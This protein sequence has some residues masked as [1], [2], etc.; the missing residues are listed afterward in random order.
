MFKRTTPQG[1]ARTTA[2]PQ[3]EPVT[4]QPDAVEEQQPSIVDTVVEQQPPTIEMKEWINIDPANLPSRGLAYPAGTTIRYRPYD[5]DE[6]EHVSENKDMPP[7]EHYELIL[8]GIKCSPMP[9]TALTLGDFLFIMLNR[10]ITSLGTSEFVLHFLHGGERYKH[11]MSVFNIEYEDIAAP[12]LPIVV[13][14][15]GVDVE[16]MP[17]T[18]GQ[19][20]EYS[21][22]PQ[23][24]LYPKETTALLALQVQ[25]MGLD[26]SYPMIANS[27]GMA[28]MRFK[29]ADRYLFHN[30]KPF[31]VPL[32]REVPNPDWNDDL[33]IEQKKFISPTI[34]KEEGRV[35]ID[36]SDESTLIMP[37]RGDI[38]TEGHGIRFG[39]R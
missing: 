11:V 39:K 19:F 20:I 8:R 5:F 29:Q 4:I 27:T 24:E 18:I 12:E 34:Q 15:N 37:F 32:T 30:V 22:N 38:E 3:Q 28:A 7:E 31:D 16:F 21:K 25:N 1:D 33:D 23:P 9:S 13:E 14:H 36:V 35:K 17:L 10:K 26:E 2:E 6:I